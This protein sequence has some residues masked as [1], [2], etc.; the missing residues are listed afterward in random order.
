MEKEKKEIGTWCLWAEIVAGPP[1]P[2]T[3]AAQAGPRQLG[4]DC[5]PA[6][7]QP[8]G[9]HLIFVALRVGLG[10]PASHSLVR[11][12]GRATACGPH[13]PVRALTPLLRR[14]HMGHRCQL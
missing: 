5:G 13:S 12:L 9:A 10:S 1:T 11:V 4:A 14:L 7:R 8:L 2:A 6:C 3:C